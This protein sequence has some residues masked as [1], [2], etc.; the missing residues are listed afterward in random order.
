MTILEKPQS[1]SRA[2]SDLMLDSR[3]TC[4]SWLET[5]GSCSGC[6]PVWGWQPPHCPSKHGINI[7]GFIWAFRFAWLWCGCASDTHTLA[8]S[9]GAGNRWPRTEPFSS[10]PPS[11]YHIYLFFLSPSISPS[12]S[13]FFFSFP[14]FQHGFPKKFFNQSNLRQKIGFVTPGPGIV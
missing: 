5:S 11:L 6:Y 7:P 4:H 9:Q 8:A 12:W 3:A 14:L 10:K 1:R 13:I 2:H